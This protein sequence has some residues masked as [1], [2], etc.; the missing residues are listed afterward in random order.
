MYPAHRLVFF[1]LGGLRRGGG[2]QPESDLPDVDAS[3]S[4]SRK[5]GEMRERVLAGGARG[6]RG[7]A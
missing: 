4:L 7:R 3:R 5:S 2:R 6:R 1:R